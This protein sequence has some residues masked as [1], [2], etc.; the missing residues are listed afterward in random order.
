MKTI[1]DYIGV[2]RLGLE[3]NYEALE[4][5]D[6]FV[7]STSKVPTAAIHTKEDAKFIALLEFKHNVPRGNH[8]HL[9]KVEH[10]IVL[11]GRL[12]CSFALPENATDTLDIILEAGQ[13]IRI[14]PGCLHTFTAQ[15]GDVLALEYAAQRYE[16]KDVLFIK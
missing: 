3:K 8:Y 2:S 4:A 13:Q 6:G 14:S 9:Q 1:N 11:Q 12:L 5:S 15:G 10:M 7:V 16:A